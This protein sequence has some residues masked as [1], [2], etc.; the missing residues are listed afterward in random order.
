MATKKRKKPPRKSPRLKREVWEALLTMSRKLV[1]ENESNTDGWGY[2]NKMDISWDKLTPKPHGFPIGKLLSDVNGV[3]TL[4]YNA[5]TVLDW[6]A[7][8][9]YTKDTAKSIYKLRHYALTS[10]AHMERNLLSADE[11][12]LEELCYNDTSENTTNIENT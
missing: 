6:L 8:K 10:L 11:K 12:L 9:N 5:C 3:R 4:R 1:M 2:K 7:L